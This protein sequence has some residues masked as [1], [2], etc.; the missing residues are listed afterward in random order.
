MSKCELLWRRTVIPLRATLSQP[1]SCSRSRFYFL[2]AVHLTL[3]FLEHVDRLYVGT[4]L[5]FAAFFY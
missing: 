3:V 2:V 4:Y 5:H 1:S